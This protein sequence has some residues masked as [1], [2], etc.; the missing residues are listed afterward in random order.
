MS[1]PRGGGGPN[2]YWELRKE[3]VILSSGLN[4]D[5]LLSTFHSVSNGQNY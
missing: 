2:Q 3:D 1:Y 5:E 4:K